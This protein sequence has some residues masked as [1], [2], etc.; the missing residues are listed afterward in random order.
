MKIDFVYSEYCFPPGDFFEVKDLFNSPK[1]ISG[2]EIQIFGNAFILASAGHDVSIYSR[3]DNPCR[4]NGINYKNLNSPQEKSDV[5]I[6]YHDAR[7]LGRWNTKLKIALHQ[8]Y[9]LTQEEDNNKFADIYLSATQKCID[10]HRRTRSLWSQ[11]KWGTVHNSWNLGTFLPWNPVP[12][13]IIFTT[14]VERGFHRLMEAFPLIKKQVPEA[15]VLVFYRGGPGLV[16]LN[17]NED[18]SVYRPSSRNKVLEVLSSASVMAYPCDP[19]SPCEVWPMSVTEACATG[20]PVVL[21]PDD[22]IEEIF[23][24]G[25]HLVPPVKQNPDTWIHEFVD[26]TVKILT[27]KSSALALSEKGKAW[28]KPY[29]FENSSNELLK[30]INGSL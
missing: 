10:F 1:G 19:P 16:G 23:A 17:S 18:I 15:H 26:Q 27:D 2:T 14:S 8:S 12:G 9:S 25:V 6:A 21:A 5:A 13:R 30:I 28:A 4:H 29:I 11:S 3:W 7:P 24:G 20:V 22:W